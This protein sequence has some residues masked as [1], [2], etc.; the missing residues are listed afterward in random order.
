M[1]KL[2]MALA[3]LPL[4][5][6]AETWYDPSTGFTWTYSLSGGKVI[7][8]FE[9]YWSSS[10]PIVSPEPSGNL[11]V[12]TTVNGVEVVGIGDLAFWDFEKITSVTIPSGVR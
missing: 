10:V 6:A 1:K 7:I 11:V 8:G 3:L 12:P 2:L 4:M 9:N 5:A